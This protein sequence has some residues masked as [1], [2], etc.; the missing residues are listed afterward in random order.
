MTR[1]ETAGQRCPVAKA[2]PK[3]DEEREER[4]TMEIV[5]DAHGPEEQAL[6]WYY[7]L[8][9]QLQFPFTATCIAKRAISPLRVKD[10]VEV[11]GMPGEDECERDMFVTVRWGK[12]GLAVPLSQLKPIRDTDEETTQ[13]VE[14][15][16]YWVL[17]GY[18]F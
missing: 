15:W 17:M 4:I 6:S 10:E 1:P 3:R 8:E 9:R 13:A 16:H 7:Y 18:E 11:T 5:V 14:D 2:R 12:Q